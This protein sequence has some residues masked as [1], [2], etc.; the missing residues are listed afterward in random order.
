MKTMRPILR[1]VNMAN[2]EVI[3]STCSRR[4]M[5]KKAY[6]F[7]KEAGKPFKFTNLKIYQVSDWAYK[8]V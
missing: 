1:C 4:Q 5:K 3:E 8:S 2:G 7:G 6:C